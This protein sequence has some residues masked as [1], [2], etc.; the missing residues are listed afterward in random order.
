[1]LLNEIKKTHKKPVESDEEYGIDGGRYVGMHFTPETKE[2][3]K[4][5]IHDEKIPTAVP[6]EKMHSTIVYSRDNPVKDYEV[7]GKLEEPIEAKINSFDVF[8]SQEGKNCLVAKLHA[9]DLED[10]HN[11]AK[12]LGASYDYDEYIPHVTLSYDVGDV[13][14]S[15]ID[16]LNKKYKGY[17][18]FADEEY[19]EPLDNT[20]VKNNA[21]S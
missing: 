14:D 1:M 21:T 4:K 19:D 16:N 12:E 5:I 15:F 9:P 20:W 2:M 10:R 6:D 18:I 3:L 17:Q 13:D 7:S 11:K 8:Q